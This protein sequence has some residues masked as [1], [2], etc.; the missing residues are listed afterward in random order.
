MD[1]HPEN[2]PPQFVGYQPF[3]E[4]S[5]KPRGPG[6][7]L[8]GAC[9]HVCICVYKWRFQ[10]KKSF[11][12]KIRI[13]CSQN[14]IWPMNTIFFSDWWGGFWSSFWSRCIWSSWGT[15]ETHV[16]VDHSTLATAR[17]SLIWKSKGRHAL[18]TTRQLRHL[19]QEESRNHYG[20]HTHTS[21]P[22]PWLKSVGTD[23]ENETVHPRAGN[24]VVHVLC[25]CGIQESW[26]KGK[27]T[28]S[29]E[30]KQVM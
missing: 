1:P 27:V 24:W 14:L 16:A 4:D 5:G 18:N 25:S 19:L 9:V 30:T 12:K 20:K 17:P 13:L 2:K 26:E 3:P 21:A 7:G 29:G 6:P 28:K 23:K 8:R 15:L 11:E 22:T 10:K